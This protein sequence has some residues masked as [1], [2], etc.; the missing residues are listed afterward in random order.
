[1]H[2]KPIF[3][4]MAFIVLCVLPSSLLFAADIVGSKDH[5]LFKRYEGSEIIKYEFHEYDS[6]AIALG[7]AKSSSELTESMQAEGAVTRLTYK[8]PMGRSPLE[9]I[10]NYENDLQAQGFTPLFA[11]SKDELGT[12]FSEAVGYKKLQWPPNIPALTLN[13][14]TQRFLALE[15]KGAEGNLVLSLYAVE[16][17][18]WAANLK[19]IEKG[20]VLLQVDIVETKPMDTKMVTVTSGEMADAISTSG[21]IALYGIYFDSDK[22]D[23]K[24][25]SAETLKQIAALLKEN[26]NL[27]LLVVGHTDTAGTFAYNMDLSSRRAASVTKELTA[28]YGAP[29]DRLTPVGVSYAC[30]VAPNKTEDGRAKNRRVAL[31]EDSH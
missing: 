8:I 10:R 23:I 2:I 6:L 29:A 21:S 20:Q 3:R 13:S 27:K 11:G 14:D 16:N 5:R 18:F 30:P 19:N 24:P 22:A 25:E 28:K 1:M 17:R 9:V 31:V 15:K 26:K 12:Y 7:K 4:I